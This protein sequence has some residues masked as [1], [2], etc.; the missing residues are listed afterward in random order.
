MPT[1]SSPCRSPVLAAVPSCTTSRHG[2]A[3]SR[4]AA[5]RRCLH[6]RGAPAA[7]PAVAPAHGAA[8][9]D[10]APDLD[11]VTLARAKGGDASARA[12]LI[13]RYQRAVYSLLWR[14]LGPDRELVEDVAQET[15][16]RVLR[17]L[18][19]FSSRG[20]ARLITWIMTI[21]TRHAIDHLRVRGTHETRACTVRGLHVVLPRP[22]QDADRRALGVALARA[23][24]ALG[25]RFRAVFLLREMDGLSYEE[26]ADA[27]QMDVGTVKSRLSRA[28]T[29]LQAAL[30]GY[31]TPGTRRTI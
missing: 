1:R 18:P 2:A 23:V 14:M 17:G 30:A 24:E 20:P 19:S 13:I 25:P 15:F 10:H 16:L 26:I 9:D 7:R 22:D 27:L 11:E 5:A 29:T 31:R 4:Y 12:L 8:G 21:A 6:H 3:L 28:R